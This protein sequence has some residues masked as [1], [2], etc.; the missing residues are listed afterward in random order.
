MKVIIVRLFANEWKREDMASIW[1][2][3]ATE[4]LEKID[5]IMFK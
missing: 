5:L 2:H 4:A 3:E 1:I